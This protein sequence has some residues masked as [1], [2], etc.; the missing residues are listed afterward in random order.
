LSEIPGFALLGESLFF[1]RQKKSNQ[2][3]GRP[4]VTPLRGRCD[5][6]QKTASLK[7]ASLRQSGP[8]IGFCLRFSLVPG[9]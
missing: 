6:R 2:K 8:L 9:R 1:F 3:K 7:L 4:A 5:A